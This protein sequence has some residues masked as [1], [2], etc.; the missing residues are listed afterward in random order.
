MLVTKT[1]LTPLETATSVLFGRAPETPPLEPHGGLSPLQAL[2]RALLEALQHRPCLIA[3]SGGRDSSALLA[4]A[5][6]VAREHGLEPPVPVT[7]RFP[8]A[9]L[10]MEDSWQELVVERLGCTDWLRLEHH[11][12]LDL[13]G[14][15]ALRVMAWDG[16]PYPYNLHL[17][18]PMLEAAGGGALVTGVGGDQALLAAGRELDVL[19]R[20]VR[21]VPRDGLRIAAGIAPSVLRR[22]VL[23]RRVRLTLPWLSDAGNEELNEAALW[24]EARRPLRWD[25]RLREMWRSRVFR[26]MLDRIDALGRLVDAEAGHPFLAARFVSALATTGGRTG[27]ADR[28]A[29]MRALFA[30]ELPDRVNTRGTKASFDQVL[31]NRHSRR[32]VAELDE[33]RLAELLRANGADGI[34]DPQALLA[35]WRMDAPMA[36]SFLL[37][38]ACRHADGA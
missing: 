11:D 28:T 22:P 27:F 26:L 35:H 2:E 18:L 12:D 31:F 19:A 4:V 37:L 34:V 25:A 23:R 24:Q 7:L 32:Y 20:R 17:L 1:S 38:Q 9:G 8:D 29:A 6:R 13:I 15:A 10:T 3:F 14:P 30:N 33:A 36:N 5:M 16:L 21:P